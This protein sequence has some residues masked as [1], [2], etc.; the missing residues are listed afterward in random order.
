MYHDVSWCKWALSYVQHVYLMKKQR[1]CC[2]G[3]CAISTLVYGTKLCRFSLRVKKSYCQER[4]SLGVSWLHNDDVRPLNMCRY[5]SI[6]DNVGIARLAT[7][8]ITSSF[9]ISPN[10]DIHFQRYW[11]SNNK[12]KEGI[13][14]GNNSWT[15]WQ[16]T[17]SS[18][19]Y[20]IFNFLFH[21]YS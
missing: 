2:T 15:S 10:D 4:H 16:E 12:K 7:S 21:T 11:F 5:I 18:I 20:S 14:R 8:L 19:P 1:H 9:D 6:L 17:T 3:V 13:V